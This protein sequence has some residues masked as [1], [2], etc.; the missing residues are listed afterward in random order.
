MRTKNLS[1]LSFGTAVT[2]TSPP[3]PEMV[4]IVR[5]RFTLVPNGVVTLPPGPAGLEP[6]RQGALSGDRYEEGDDERRGP[7]LHPSDF[8]P[9]KP[10]AE[11][12]FSG[13]AY[14]PGAG[15][16]TECLVSIA[17]GPW[18]KSLRV[19][20]RRRYQGIAGHRPGVPAPFRRMGLDW[21]HSA[22]GPTSATNPVGLGPHGAFAPNVEAPDDA[23]GP[24]GR[25]PAGFGTI[26]PSWSPRRERIGTAYGE[27]YRARAPWF[28]SDFQWSYFNAAPE[29]QWLPRPPRGDEWL[30][31]ENLHP[32]H[33]RLRTQLP[34]LRLRCFVNDDRG[35]TREVTM[36]LDTVFVDGDAEELLLTWRGRTEVR[37]RELEDVTTVLIASEPLAEAPLPADRYVARLHAFEADPL[38]LD[39]HVSGEELALLQA[40]S[41]PEDEAKA[42]LR[43]IERER[44]GATQTAA[45]GP[46]GGVDLERVLPAALAERKKAA[47]PP[48]V[49][50]PDAPR[51]HLGI[52]LGDIERALDELDAHAPEQ[53]AALRERL[54]DPRLQA[55]DPNYRPPGS[56]P[57][58]P[59]PPLGPGVD[60]EGRDLSDRK[61][62]GAD[63]REANLTGAILARANLRGARL[64]GARLE[65]ALLFAADLTDADLAGAHLERVNAAQA[66]VTR[67][68]FS[69]SRL[70]AAFFGGATGADACFDEVE[71]THVFFTEAELVRASFRRCRLERADFERA[72]LP[73]ARFARA[74]LDACLFYRATLDAAD[75]DGASVSKCTFE[76]AELNAAVLTGVEGAAVNFT[77]CRMSTTDVRYAA[78]EGAHFTHADAAGTRFGAADLRGARF[79]KADLEGASFRRANLMGADFTATRVDRVS[80]EGAHLYDADLSRAHGEDT[81]FAGAI[82]TRMRR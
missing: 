63:L 57:E 77:R 74:T 61:L 44:P 19:V 42:M 8:A 58:G 67:A 20:G 30:E 73:E 60:L 6:V 2:S 71:G 51:A 35:A 13:H 1:G 56:K 12:L 81:H 10:R 48:P 66:N 45:S 36:T 55:L 78:L 80:F 50:H 46:D 5:G 43:L 37:D 69:R 28:A 15:T 11:I 34:G 68:N 27:G 22:G 26:S 70:E 39:E 16:V 75:F 21:R 32:Q 24:A 7:L 29:D 54:Q 9:L 25:T 79:F 4:L 64:A 59:E 31:L 40:A 23:S 47:L 17:L 33:A 52:D 53:A 49:P 14:A 3:Q 65:G 41:D 18:R 38:A 76:E 82:T 72:H 62:A